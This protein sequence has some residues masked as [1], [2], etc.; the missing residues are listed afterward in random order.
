MSGALI[1]LS[2]SSEDASLARRLAV[3]LQ[4]RGVDVWLDLWSLQVGEDIA[5]RIERAV[6]RADIVL[7][8]VSPSSIASGWV[9]REWRRKGVGEGR[10]LPVICEHCEMPDNIAS[11]SV[12]DVS[13]GAYWSGVA[14][15]MDVIRPQSRPAPTTALQER[16]HFLPL[17]TPVLVEVGRDLIPTVDAV[18][19][20]RSP[21]SFEIDAMQ[22]RL[23]RWFGMPF[24]GIRFRGTDEG[25]PPNVALLFLEDV[26]REHV[27]IEPGQDTVRV[28][29][30]RLERLMADGADLFIDPDRAAQILAEQGLA[31]PTPARACWSEIV[32][33]MREML[34]QGLPLTEFGPVIN[35]LP[36]GRSRPLDTAGFVEEV[37]PV[38]AER[39]TQLVMGTDGSVRAI[40]LSPES[41][42]VI[43]GAIR[44]DLLFPVLTLGPR[45]TDQ[46]L[47]E[48]R[49]TSQT[50]APTALV[51]QQPEIRR[52]VERM[53]LSKLP[54]IARRDLDPGV[55]I[56]HA[57]IVA[58]P[59][60]SD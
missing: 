25:L 8:L 47:Q 13:G 30:D 22:D 53:M 40:T 38:H 46:L 52:F 18:N 17:P 5:P 9:E 27:R 57:G 26:F 31:D 41:E 50:S 56:K 29:I 36:E 23:S 6:D 42:A 49:R 15:L 54:V 2:Y 19:D 28:L 44:D 51:V 55:D 10:V 24:A 59:S 37:R 16:R 20:P 14:Q 3:D 1:F 12:I 7:V 4:A 45:W 39:L 60:G 58:H 21:L 43:F 11:Q 32:E 35:G 33:I 48:I 34:R